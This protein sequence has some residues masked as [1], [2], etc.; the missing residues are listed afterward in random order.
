MLPFHRFIYYLIYFLPE[1]NNDDD[2]EAKSHLLTTDQASISTNNNNNNN[3]NSLNNSSTNESDE[4]DLDEVTTTATYENLLDTNE[5][6]T[7]YKDEYKFLQQRIKLI[8]AYFELATEKTKEQIRM[9]PHSLPV[10][11]DAFSLQIPAEL[12]QKIMLNSQQINKQSSIC[13]GLNL[14]GATYQFNSGSSSNSANSN[15]Y[16]TLKQAQNQLNNNAA[17]LLHNQHLPQQLQQQQLQQ[18]QYQQ[19]KQKQLQQNIP[20]AQQY[21]QKMQQQQQQLQQNAPVNNFGGMLNNTNTTNANTVPVKKEK[22]SK[23]KVH[24]FLKKNNGPS[25]VYIIG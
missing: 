9:A 22:I 15:G 3:N 1:E 5:E 25:L 4:D 18:L 21:Q 19:Q 24:T 7:I 10:L 12:R 6:D 8:T 14:N 20:N 11:Q 2:K 13:L 17:R 23:K 16:L